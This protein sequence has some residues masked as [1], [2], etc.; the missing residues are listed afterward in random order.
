MDYDDLL[1]YETSD[2]NNAKFSFVVSQPQPLLTM[3]TTRGITLV[4]SLGA[5][6][7]PADRSLATSMRTDRVVAYISMPHLV[8]LD[9]G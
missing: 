4:V 8:V 7:K 1:V 6:R 9:E 3:E 5:L 2:V